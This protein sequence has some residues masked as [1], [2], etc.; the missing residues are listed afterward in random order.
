M[1]HRALHGDT[2]VLPTPA[3][4]YGLRVGEESWADIEGGKTLIVKLLSIGDIE[5]DGARVLTFE[6]NGQ[7]RQMRV[8]DESARVVGPKRRKATSGKKGEIGAPMPGR[9]IDLVTKVGEKVTAGQK[10]LVTEAMKLETVVKAPISG[11]VREIVAGAGESVEAGDL[12]VVI[13]EAV[14]VS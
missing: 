1:E 9:V 2:S 12:L 8:A 4:F 14:G 5:A 7:P 3:F 11:L 10:L 13:D 6:L